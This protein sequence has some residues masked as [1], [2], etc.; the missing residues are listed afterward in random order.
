[1]KRAKDSMVIRGD[2]ATY[3]A[4]HSIGEG[5]MEA[6]VPGMG[7]VTL[8]DDPQIDGV[9]STGEFPNEPVNVE[10]AGRIIVKSLYD[11]SGSGGAEV[12]L[13]AYDYDGKL[14]GFT[15]VYVIEN[16]GLQDESGN[17]VGDL[18]VLANEMGAMSVSI[19]ITKAPTGNISMYISNV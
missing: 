10:G 18:L 8:P 11:A 12:R 3:K 7:P 13:K 1:M 9:G 4:G 14:I 19:Q 16:L 17:Y 15:D 5:G 6:T 2:A